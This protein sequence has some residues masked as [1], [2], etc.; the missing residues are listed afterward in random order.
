MKLHELMIRHG[1][2]MFRWRSYI[3]LL[4]IGPLLLAFR[5]SAHIEAMVGD[6]AED[7]WVLFCFILS[8]SG[9]A[10]RAF[11]VGFVPAGTSGRNAKQQ[12]AEVLNTTGLYSIVRNPLYLANFI[13]ILGVLL[14]IKVWWLVALASLVFFVYMERII[15]T[16][17]SFLL[18]KF[19]KTYSDWCEKTPVILPNFKLWKPSTMTFSMKTVLRREYPG[20]L[21][22]GTAFFVT[23]MIQDLVYE[24]EAFREW[25]A[26][27]YIWPITYGIIIATCLSLRHLKKN[28]DLLKVEGR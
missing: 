11:T 21:G 16:E 23:E 26:E 3:P 8:L 27:D 2:S 9:L 12:R 19:G 4:F 25:I 10:L 28:T 14:S 5:E 15:L 22:I 18:G 13:I 6:A 24:G 1:H 20:L 17:E 7:V